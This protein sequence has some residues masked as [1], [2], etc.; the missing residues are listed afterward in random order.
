MSDLTNYVFSK[1]VGALEG[2]YTLVRRTSSP[3]PSSSS[4]NKEAHDSDG[5]QVSPVSV[6]VSTLDL[7]VCTRYLLSI[8]D[9]HS[10]LS[11]SKCSYLPERM[12]A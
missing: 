11:H 8:V 2:L 10:C 1:A 12:V 4:M 5:N 7:E 9:G 6:G 3:V